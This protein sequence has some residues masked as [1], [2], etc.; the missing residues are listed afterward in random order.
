MCPVS[1][2]LAAAQRVNVLSSYACP[3]CTMNDVGFDKDVCVN[4]NRSVTAYWQPE[5][6]Q[7]SQVS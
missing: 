2:P 5:S 1:L 6:R 3:V 7:A 4:G